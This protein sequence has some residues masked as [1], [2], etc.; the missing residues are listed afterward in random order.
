MDARGMTQRCE[1][2]CASHCA[3]RCAVS[4]TWHTFLVENAYRECL[5]QLFN[6]EAQKTFQFKAS[7]A[8]EHV[9]GHVFVRLLRACVHVRV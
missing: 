2:G 4:T 8:R 3:Q 6:M 9:Q 5:L 1:P 7:T